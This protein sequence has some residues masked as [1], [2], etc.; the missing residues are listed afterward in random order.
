MKP[1]CAPV[2]GLL[3][4]G[5]VLTVTPHRHAR[6]L[7]LRR[8]KNELQLTVPYGYPSDG[9]IDK[10]LDLVARFDAKYPPQQHQRYFIGQLISC[11]DVDIELYSQSARPSHVII[12]E[13][14]P[15]SRLGI[16]SALDLADAATE[17]FVSSVLCRLA[18]KLAP[19]LLLPHAAQVAA[20]VGVSPASWRIGRGLRTLGTCSAQRVITLS[21][22]LVFL[23]LE[24][25]EYII[26][27]E[28]AHLTEM[29]HSARF[30]ALC[31]SY[32][33]GKEKPLMDALKRH[34]W[35][36]VR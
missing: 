27:H 30:H 21:C 19:R 16:G 10:I 18:C 12:G 34:E 24:L 5:R 8:K 7:V 33:R 13:G 23:P 26:C 32:L 14:I 1:L 36:I 3:P 9:L 25:R 35:P 15:H 17:Q 29:N 28:L 11:H 4:D 22:A 6:T 20:R 31:N 2:R